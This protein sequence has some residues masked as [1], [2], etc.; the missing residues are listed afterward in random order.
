MKYV[1]SLLILSVFLMSCAKK[2]AE[3]QAIE[4]AV[5]IQQYIADNGLMAIK[6]TSGLNYVRNV[7]GG[8][9][10][11]S[12]LSTVT[13]AYKGYFTDGTVF[14]ESPAEGITFSLSAVIPGWTE[15]IPYFKE[16]G[17]GVLLVPSALGYGPKGRGSIPGNTVLVFD[18]HLIEVVE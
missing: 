18:V 16:G 6:N 13:V 7:V 12:A 4:D 8:G 9:A 11:C 15:G 5:I 17:N 1:F 10:S 2:K 3:N 14:D